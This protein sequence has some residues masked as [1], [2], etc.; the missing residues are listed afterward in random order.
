M[1]RIAG[2]V[3][4]QTALLT[5]LLFYFGWVRTRETYAYFGVDVELLDFSTSDYLLRSVNSAFPPLMA[6]GLLTVVLAALHDRR[7]TVVA[8]AALAIGAASVAIGLTGIAVGGFGHSLGIALPICL[9]AG[10]S[11]I[12]YGDRTAPRLRTGVLLGLALLGLFWSVSLYA[13]EIGRS[14]AEALHRR[15]HSEIQAVLFSERRLSI[16]GRGV[17]H[18]TQ[19]SD[20]RYRHRYSGL[21]LLAEAQDRYFL[22]PVD[23]VK[24]DSV[25][26]IP[27]SD[28]IRLDFQTAPSR[29]ARRSG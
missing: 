8:P 22:L 11:L 28:D 18:A 14:R 16:E 12:A 24:G 5:G 7:T 23:W 15:L 21:L 4:P 13:I 1:R 25:F 2:A 6:I 20:S 17:Q 3:L 27:E 9:T 29:S 10:F 19:P 26:L